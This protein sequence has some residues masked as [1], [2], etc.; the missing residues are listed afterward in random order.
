[1]Q[2]EAPGGVSVERSGGDDGAVSVTPAAAGF[3]YRPA[4]DGL[5]AVSVLAV[6]AY[7]L[8]WSWAPG[9]FMGVDG[10]FVLSGYLI[11]SLLL[12]ERDGR[13]SV[14]L[15]AFWARRARRLLPALLLLLLAVSVWAAVAASAD[16][17]EALRGDGLATLF[18]SANWHLVLSGQSYFDL[19]RAPSPLRHTWSLAIEEQFYLLWPLIVVVALRVARGRRWFLAASSVAGAAAS[20]LVMAALYEEAD[21]SRAYYGTD[22]RAHSL[23]VGVVLAIVLARAG[24]GAARSRL[25]QV[26][27]VAGAVGIVW[28]FASGDDQG[29]GYYRGGSLLFAVAVAVVIAAS[30]GEARSPLRAALSVAPL[31]WVG[32]I[33][34]GVYLWHWPVQV[35]LTRRLAGVDGVALDAARVALTFAAATASYFVIEQPMRHSRASAR[36][37]LA[38]APVAMLAVGAAVLVGT[39]G[40][41]EET[42]A[43]D[44]AVPITP[45]ADPVAVA[46]PVTTPPVTGS[47]PAN[48][49]L[50]SVPAEPA[51]PPVIA[52]VGDSVATTIVW[53]LEEVAP[54]QGITIVSSAFPGCGVANGFAVDDDGHPFEWSEPCAENIGPAHDGLISRHDPDLVV[55]L[56]TWDLADRLVDGEVVRAGTPE[57]DSALLGSMEEARKRL[58]AGGARVVLLTVAPNAPSDTAP[59]DDDSDGEKSHYAALLRRFAAA[60]PRTVSV[61]DLAALVC[62]GGPPCPEEVDGIRLRPDGGHFTRET[63]PWVAE[64][65]VPMLLAEMGG[66]P[67]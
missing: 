58:T 6:I 63:S 41:R 57:G 30:V 49:S 55:W 29:P 10:F 38:L 60:H 26:L 43:F 56:S 2:R 27:G 65:L 64:R 34:Y 46:Q 61:V 20:A 36:R 25:V 48:G 4:L 28:A 1:M 50:P 15:A 47:T 32:M 17:L 62:P 5:R 16:R 67:S 11:T 52:V 33:S 37:V 13:G 40:A 35:V 42:R 51:E 8:G 3:A 54:P 12:V 59:A 31:R 14:D 44:T 66:P 19:F 39:L 45:P 21:P 9:G 24:A 22:A 18:Y 53:G 23:L 7:H